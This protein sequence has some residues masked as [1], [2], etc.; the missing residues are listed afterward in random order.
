[1]IIDKEFLDSH[2][3]YILCM[4]GI[5][6]TTFGNVRILVRD[7]VSIDAAEIDLET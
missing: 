6:E 7:K 1:M 2:V 3:R 4:A 5:F